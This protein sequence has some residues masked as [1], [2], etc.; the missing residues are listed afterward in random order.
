MDISFMEGL[1]TLDAKCCKSLAARF[2]NMGIPEKAASS[3]LATL[4]EKDAVPTRI[5]YAATPSTF[6]SRSA[7][8]ALNAQRAMM[9]T[10]S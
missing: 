10:A 1:D 2:A 7:A 5:P 6:P 4:V 3:A 8:D 9:P